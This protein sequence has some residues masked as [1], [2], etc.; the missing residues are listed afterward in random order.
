MPMTV[1]VKPDVERRINHLAQKTKRTKAFYL[2]LLIEE[3]LEELED[4][5]LAAEILERVRKGEEKVYSA[6][7]VEEMLGLAD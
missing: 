5:Y 1:C 4:I 3:N 7:E 2:N 6:K